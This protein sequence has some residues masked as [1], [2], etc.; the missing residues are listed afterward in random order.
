MNFYPSSIFILFL[1]EML[2]LNYVNSMLPFNGIHTHTDG[3]KFYLKPLIDKYNI[4]AET[5]L[6]KKL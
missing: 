6:R 5:E 1:F 2:Q 4:R 3:G